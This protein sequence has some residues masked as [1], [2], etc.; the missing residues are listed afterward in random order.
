VISIFVEIM[1]LNGNMAA[2]FYIFQ[3]W[4][5]PGQPCNITC[6]RISNGF[7]PVFSFHV[8]AR[9]CLLTP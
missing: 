6:Q 1:E 2:T 7:L 4:R 5:V 8:V 3:L 9:A